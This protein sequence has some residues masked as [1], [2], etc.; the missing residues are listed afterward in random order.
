MSTIASFFGGSAAVAE[1]AVSPPRAGKDEVPECMDVDR[2]IV[3]SH[4]K[5]GTLKGELQ[6]YGAS[7]QGTKAVLA[8]RL[9]GLIAKRNAARGTSTFDEAP[10]RA[11]PA[12]R[13]RKRKQPPPLPSQDETC[14]GTNSKPRLSKS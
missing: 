12:D 8:A 13:A 1:R 4:L 10:A 11:E 2:L 3:G 5:R 14:A 6:Y 9:K 7:Y